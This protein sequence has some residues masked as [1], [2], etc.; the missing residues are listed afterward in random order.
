VLRLGWVAHH[1]ESPADRA[2]SIPVEVCPDTLATMPTYFRFGIGPFRFSQRLGR[3]EAQKRAAAKAQAQAT[4]A[5]T[6]LLPRVL[7]LL[8][9][10]LDCE[11]SRH[12]HFAVLRGWGT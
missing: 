6:A 4:Y 3:T 9:E 8:W 5:D 7:S 10:D 12:R 2:S 1:A 11:Y